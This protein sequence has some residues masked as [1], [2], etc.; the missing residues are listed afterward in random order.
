M[1][2]CNTILLSISGM[3]GRLWQAIYSS[4]ESQ[5]DAAAQDAQAI[6]ASFSTFV[7]LNSSNY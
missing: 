1:K 4:T 3:F 7:Q 5:P 2:F 6:E